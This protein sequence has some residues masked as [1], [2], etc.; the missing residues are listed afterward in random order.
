[1]TM[2]YLDK[3]SKTQDELP[4]CTCNT[5]KFKLQSKLLKAQNKNLKKEAKRHGYKGELET[6]ACFRD[7]TFPKAIS[8][9]PF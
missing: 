6:S 4:R 9:S 5:I 7:R 8:K 1:M 2:I 3:N